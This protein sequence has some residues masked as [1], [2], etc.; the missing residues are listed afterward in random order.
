MVNMSQLIS[1]VSMDTEL[2]SLPTSNDRILNYW[3]VDIFQKV[4]EFLSPVLSSKS[5]VRRPFLLTL[6][7]TRGKCNVFSL[8]NIVY[9]QYTFPHVYLHYSVKYVSR[10]QP[11]QVFNFFACQGRL[12]ISIFGSGVEV[13]A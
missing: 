8:S 5:N 9:D 1:F 13:K 10:L 2:M 11:K 3:N 4:I 12:V 6:N 7:T